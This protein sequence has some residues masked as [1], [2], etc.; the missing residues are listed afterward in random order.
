[1]CDGTNHDLEEIIRFGYDDD[2]Q[3]VVRWC[4]HCGAVVVDNE[5]DYRLMGKIVKM[6]F[7][8]LAYDWATRSKKMEN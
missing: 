4:S 1:M 2:E 3:A 5:Y 8:Q 7:P 6:K